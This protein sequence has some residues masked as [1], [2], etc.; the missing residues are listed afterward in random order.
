MS[1]ATSSDGLNWGTPRPIGGLTSCFMEIL[2]LESQ[3]ILPSTIKDRFLRYRRLEGSYVDLQI[4]IDQI[5]RVL[6]AARSDLD[7]VWV[8]FRQQ[9]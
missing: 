2:K 5:Q 7:S 3:L 9:Q 6:R 8:R 1:L 4:A